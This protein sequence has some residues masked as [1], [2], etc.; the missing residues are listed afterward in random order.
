MKYPFK[1]TAAYNTKEIGRERESEREGG[2]R[3]N[4]MEKRG[5]EGKWVRD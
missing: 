5:K 1:S 4:E 3:G 2:G